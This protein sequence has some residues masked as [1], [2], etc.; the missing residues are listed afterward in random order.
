MGYQQATLNE[1]YLD[2]K[3]ALRDHTQSTPPGHAEGKEMIQT[4]TS[5]SSASES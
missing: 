1:N 3:E 2:F 4:T 5:A